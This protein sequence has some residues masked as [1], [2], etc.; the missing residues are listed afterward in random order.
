MDN[1]ELIMRTNAAIFHDLY[2]SH[3]NQVIQL[4]DRAKAGRIP[5]EWRDIGEDIA[6]RF[7]PTDGTIH[8]RQNY[9]EP[10][11][12]IRICWNGFKRE[13]NYYHDHYN[14]RFDEPFIDDCVHIRASSGDNLIIERI[15]RQISRK[16]RTANGAFYDRMLLI[17]ADL[18]CCDTLFNSVVASNPT[19]RGHRLFPWLDTNKWRRWDQPPD[20]RDYLAPDEKLVFVGIGTPM[21]ERGSSG[22]MTRLSPVPRWM[23]DLVKPPVH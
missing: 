11:N 15:Q 17:G 5:V 2:K 3:M 21:I 9:G 8:I 14:R 23:R 4:I 12:K 1:I 22:Y 10:N 19:T 13:I 18:H 6:T 20:Y 16:D 7:D